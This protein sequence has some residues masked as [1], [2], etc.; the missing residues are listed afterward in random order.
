MNGRA[1][2]ATRVAHE[3]DECVRIEGG[4]ILAVLAAATGDLQL[5]EDAT[6][7]ATIAALEVWERTGVP[8][9]PAGWLYVAARRK[10]IDI[11]R[12]EAT[13]RPREHAADVLAEQLSVTA[14]PERGIRD[15]ELRL[16]F[17]C[18]HPA[19]DLESRVALALR[20]LCGL[21][22]AEV[23]RALLVSEHTMA[24]RLVRTKQ[25]ITV[26]GIPYRIPDTD[27][28]PARLERGVRRDPPRV[29]HWTPRRDRRRGRPRRPVC[30][31]HPPRPAGGGPR[32]R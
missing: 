1:G 15:D 20:T 6:Q 29:H 14:P 25:K 10:A 32:P 9:N 13:R 23:A 16:I 28:L 21:S 26:A 7:D 22:T 4:R 24:K 17:T 8:A 27:E 19:L 30:G 2:D 5:A 18:C 11:A 12:R 3:L 31:G